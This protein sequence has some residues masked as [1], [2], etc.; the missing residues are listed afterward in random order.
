[1]IYELNAHNENIIQYMDTDSIYIKKKFVDWL[2]ESLA[3]D[4]APLITWKNEK[5]R[6]GTFK[7]DFG[8]GAAIIEA[9]YAGKKM[10]GMKV[11]GEFDEFDFHKDLCLWVPKKSLYK[12]THEKIKLTFKGVNKW[13]I[14]WNTFKHLK[15]AT[16]ETESL[17]VSFTRFDSKI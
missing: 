12:R 15:E 8:E 1:M 3:F 5:D 6:L 4:G 16:E 7:N 2:A 10:K 13:C 11:V 14:N 17:T 9:I